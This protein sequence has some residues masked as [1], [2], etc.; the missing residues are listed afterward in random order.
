MVFNAIAAGSPAPT[1]QWTFNGAPITGATD[2]ILLVSNATSASAGSYACVAMN[3][4]GPS[5]SNSATLT[6][7]SS[8]NAGYLINISARADVGTGNNILI[9]GFGVTGTGTKPLL[10]RGVGPGLFNTFGLAGELVTPQLIL[11]DNSGAVVA[12]NIGWAN[13]PAR[14][15]STASES[16]VAAGA[17]IMATLGAF[18]YNAGSA[19]TSMLLTMPPGNNTAQVS[20]VGATS[21]IAL[22]EI[23][24]ADTGAPSARLINI[25]ARANVGTA[26]SILIGGF[27][28]GGSTAETLLIRAVGPGLTDTFGLTGTLA[29]PVLALLNNNGAVIYTNTVW[30]GDATIASISTTVGA[31]TLN[32]SHQDSVLL[33]TLPPGNYTAQ[34]SGLNSGNGIA[35]C[36][37]YE[38]Q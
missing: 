31:F 38:V 26:D 12:T 17:T 20:G 3:S 37:I 36:E 28:I 33:V 19:D 16:P 8:S 14:G 22:C 18:S 32:P 13:S 11:L 10:I 29:Q 21:G 24:D 23:Y 7:T 27:A 6:V 30:G 9:G 34:V 2:A 5:T 25:S 35:L 15:L 4:N 1:Y